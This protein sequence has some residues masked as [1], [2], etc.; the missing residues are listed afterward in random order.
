MP[1]Q[2]LTRAQDPLVML[3]V[4]AL[5]AGWESIRLERPAEQASQVQKCHCGRA[6][7]EVDCSCATISGHNHA[8]DS[9]SGGTRTAGMREADSMWIEAIR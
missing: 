5:V 6:A 4:S 7:V 3:M 2:R 8:D 9:S 1:C